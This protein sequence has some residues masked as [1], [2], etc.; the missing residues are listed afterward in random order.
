MTLME[1]L[2]VL[3]ILAV[4]ATIAVQ[5]LQPRVELARFEQTRKTLEQLEVATVGSSTARHADGSPLISGFIADVGRAPRLTVP[6]LPK[7]NPTQ[8]K[9][10]AP[11]A[12]MFDGDIQEDRNLYELWD[13]NSVLAQQYP[14]QFR[15]GPSQPVDFSDIRLACGWKGPYLS[16]PKGKDSVVD[17]WA[18]DFL[19]ETN[20]NE[21]VS[22]I[23]WK[24]VGEF[25]LPLSS[26]LSKGR[27]IVS[28][29]IDFGQQTSNDVKVYMLVPDPEYSLTELRPIEDLDPAKQ[30]FQFENV[31]VGLRAIRVIADGKSFTK[32][33]NVPLGGL[34]LLMDLESAQ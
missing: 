17:A 30:T 18:Q 19:F 26:D 11:S 2:V 25:D 31:P 12:A 28:G 5:A 14:F 3:V 29:N 13:E 8:P 27:V 24:P 20:E 16:L 1:L 6:S 21:E 15:S 10:S 4:V 34:T 32:Y 23:N 7:E 33:V 22:R 9:S